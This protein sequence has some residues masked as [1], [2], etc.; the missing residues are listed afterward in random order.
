M[1]CKNCNTVLPD[2]T[3]QCPVCGAKAEVVWALSPEPENRALCAN[4]GYALPDGTDICPNCGK[5]TVQPDAPASPKRRKKVP[6]L[7]GILAAVLV[8]AALLF[9]FLPSG[10]APLPNFI[11]YK[12]DGHYFVMDAAGGT[13]IQLHNDPIMKLYISSDGQRLV[14]RTQEKELMLCDTDG[15]LPRQI[16]ENVKSFK[17]NAQG[18]LI[19]YQ[20]GTA[21]LLYDSE[22]SRRIATSI[23]DY[24]ISPDGAQLVYTTQLSDVQALYRYNAAKGESTELARAEAVR[25]LDFAEDLQTVLFSTES[26]T[27]GDASMLCIQTG[28]NPPQMIAEHAQLES[29]LYSD[30]S[31]YYAVRFTQELF[32][33]FVTTSYKL[34]Y[35]D[36]TN[37]IV[38]DQNVRDLL[39]AA[40]NR[41]G[42]IYR[43]EDDRLCA[44]VGANSV[45]LGEARYSN[46]RFDPDATKLLLWENGNLFSPAE[47]SLDLLDIA[48]GETQRIHTTDG[49]LKD[50]AFLD[51]EHYCYC[52][53]KLSII[54][55]EQPTQDDLYLDGKL[56]EA[57]VWLSM[58]LSPEL[59]LYYRTND[60][61]STLCAP[62]GTVTKLEHLLS[63]PGREA[64]TLTTR[65]ELMYILD[66]D[67]SGTGALYLHNGSG[68]PIAEN[69]EG[70]WTV[71]VITEAY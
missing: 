71:F 13:P 33:D 22:S 58:I 26:P 63:S 42:I 43:D 41:P 31:F 39:P 8:L 32:P 4:C 17:M 40:A 12:Q 15:S 67:G 70:I 52:V 9:V 47:G 54:S 60:D 50:V 49:V 16:S 10:D 62:D 30:G 20:P 18:T 28:E 11:V 65:G 56:V 59:G 45:S 2:G 57:N 37:H 7:L 1:T 3:A 25:I 36:G 61:T 44:A 19:Y 35:F 27:S 46:A 55:S 68:T 69:I 48:S 21:L 23:L 34:C 5:P 6:L 29:P 38:L 51:S 53:T 64:R 66:E 14:Y 24:Y